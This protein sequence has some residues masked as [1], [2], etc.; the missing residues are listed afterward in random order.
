MSADLFFRVFEH[1]LPQALPFLMKIIGSGS[2]VGEATAIQCGSN[3][4][5]QCGV[6]AQLGGLYDPILTA[7]ATS[8]HGTRRL[9]GGMADS[10][11]DQR[12]F[13]DGV[14]LDVFPAT[15]RDLPSWEEQFALGPVGLSEDD[16][17]ERV[18]AA[19]AALGGQSPRYL[20]DT[21]QAA[22]FDVYLYEWWE[23]ENPY[24]PRTP[25]VYLSDDGAKAFII[26]CDEDLAECGEAGAQAGETAGPRGSILVNPGIGITYLVPTDPLEWPYIL[27]W[28]GAVFPEFATVPQSRREEFEDLILRLSPGQQWHGLLVDYS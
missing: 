21:V 26:A 1:L 12:E 15:T 2:E 17:R 22:G 13:A 8:Q 16:R 20:Q 18:A 11:N 9:F 10:Q 25:S 3:P 4:L 7:I 27:Y 14:Y 28:A 24:V 6:Q 19:W 5:V 23:S